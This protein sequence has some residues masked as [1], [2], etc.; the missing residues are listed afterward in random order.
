MNQTKHA[1]TH[2]QWN[3]RCEKLARSI[4][5]FEQKKRRERDIKQ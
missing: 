2:T 1:Q 3:E 5:I 4:E